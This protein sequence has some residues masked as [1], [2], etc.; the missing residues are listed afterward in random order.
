MALPFYLGALKAFQHL[1][2]I[3]LF[4]IINR[5]T[6][7]LKLIFKD[8]VCCCCCRAMTVGGSCVSTLALGQ[9]A[10]W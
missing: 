8:R 3:L 1:A 5:W 9:S 4:F 6:L 2:D 10:D 7:L